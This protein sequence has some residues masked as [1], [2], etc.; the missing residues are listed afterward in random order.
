MTSNPRQ[1]CKCRV[2]VGGG[3]ASPAVSSPPLCSLTCPPRELREK[4]Q[5]EILELIKQQRL[6]R[7]CEGSSFRKIGNRRR[8]GEGIWATRLVRV[9]PLGREPA[10]QSRAGSSLGTRHPFALRVLRPFP[11]LSVVTCLSGLV[12]QNVSGTAAWP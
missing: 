5:P 10:G 12:F 7:L 11:E 1:S 6:N 9:T 4:I 3:T 2:W 8:Q